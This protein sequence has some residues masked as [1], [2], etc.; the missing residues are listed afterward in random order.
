LAG[1]NGGRVSGRT[2]ADDGEVIDSFRQSS[3]P[4]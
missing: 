3:R 2:A 1:A 4:Q